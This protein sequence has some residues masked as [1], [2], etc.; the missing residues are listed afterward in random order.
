MPY[1]TVIFTWSIIACEVLQSLGF[2]SMLMAF[3]QGEFCIVYIYSDLLTGPWFF[4]PPH[5]VTL[6]NKQGVLR[7]Y[8][9]L[10]WIPTGMTIL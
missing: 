9:K 3:E 4:R 2:C 7:T 8:S 10:E 1:S 6:Y 5:L